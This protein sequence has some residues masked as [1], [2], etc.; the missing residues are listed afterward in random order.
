MDVSMHVHCHN[1]S[2]YIVT[3]IPISIGTETPLGL[4]IGLLA[5][6]LIILIAVIIVTICLATVVV[7]KRKATIRSLQLEGQ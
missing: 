3:I 4:V 2:S 5:A 1:S 6:F 7:R